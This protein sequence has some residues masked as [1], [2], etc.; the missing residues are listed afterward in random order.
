MPP[1]RSR[2]LLRRHGVRS[3]QHDVSPD[4]VA[5]PE[6]LELPTTWFLRRRLID[7]GRNCLFDLA[8]PERFE[9]P[10]PWFVAG[11]VKIEL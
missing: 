11:T 2:S 5:R 10:T 8:R 7:R 1:T 4:W 6:A 3:T 9:L